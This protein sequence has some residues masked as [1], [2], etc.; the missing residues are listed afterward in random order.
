MKFRNPAKLAILILVTSACGE[1]KD[2]KGTSGLRGPDGGILEFDAAQLGGAGGGSGATAGNGGS[3]NGAS[4]ASGTLGAAGTTGSA[5]TNGASGSGGITSDAGNIDAGG[6][7]SR[8]T[9]VPTPCSLNS[10]ATCES[11]RGCTR[12][13]RCA[14]VSSSCYSQYSSYSCTSLRGCYWSSSSSSCS[15][16]SWSCSAM[17]GSSSC[18]GQDGCRWEDDCTG[19]A[20]PCSLMTEAECVTQ[21]GCRLERQ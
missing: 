12:D 10:G 18:I 11:T 5:G 16:S 14:G 19:V 8:C 20:T 2:A 3:G 1:E 9:G 17:S 15:G 21:V 13:E 4:G 6:G 7:S